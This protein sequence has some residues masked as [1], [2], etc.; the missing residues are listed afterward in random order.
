M[1]AKRNCLFGPLD[2]GVIGGEDDDDEEEAEADTSSLELS[3]M[4]FLCRFGKLNK[5]MHTTS[6]R[7]GSDIIES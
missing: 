7:A 5:L 6:K 2:S 3:D 4:R 1:M